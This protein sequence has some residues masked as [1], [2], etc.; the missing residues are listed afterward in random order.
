MATDPQ[1]EQPRLGRWRAVVGFVAA[2][3][4]VVSGAVHSMLGWPAVTKEFA[5]TNAPPALVQGLAVPWHFTALSMLTFGAIVAITLQRAVR[6]A[7]ESLAVVMVIG[8]AY[9]V[10]GLV[11]LALTGG[12]AT[13]LM[14]LVPGVMLVVTA[15]RPRGA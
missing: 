12:N 4:Q 7:D 10:F 8:A 3:L 2:G 13:F 11:G 15:W 6:R 1:R 5:A 14:F 9:V